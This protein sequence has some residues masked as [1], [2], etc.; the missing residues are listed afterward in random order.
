M[1][2]LM[3]FLGYNTKQYTEYLVS[4]DSVDR[5][6]PAAMNAVD[7]AA[8]HGLQAEPIHLYGGAIGKI[9]QLK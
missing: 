8:A 5:N 1:S 6:G 9:Y 2:V 3:E 4:S 7:C